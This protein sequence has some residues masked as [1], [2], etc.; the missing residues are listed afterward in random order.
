MEYFICF[1]SSDL[2][3]SKVYSMSLTPLITINSLHLSK[4]CNHGEYHCENCSEY[5]CRSHCKD[6]LE[7]FC[8][9]HFEV[10]YND[11]IKPKAPNF[12]I[13]NEIIEPYNCKCKKNVGPYYNPTISEV[14]RFQSNKSTNKMFNNSYS[15]LFKFF[16]ISLRIKKNISGTGFR[17][18]IRVSTFNL[19]VQALNHQKKNNFA[20]PSTTCTF[21]SK[22]NS[23]FTNFVNCLV[24]NN[25]RYCFN[26]LQITIYI[27]PDDLHSFSV[28]LYSYFSGNWFS[29]GDVLFLN[30]SYCVEMSIKLDA[31]L[32][33]RATRELFMDI[34]LDIAVAC[35]V[36]AIVNSNG[37]KSKLIKITQEAAYNTATLGIET[38][39]QVLGNAVASAA[40][41]G[42]V[43]VAF[44]S[45]SI[46]LAKRRRD[47]GEMSEKEFSNKVKKTV[48]E[49]SLKF[50]GGTTG[51]IIGQALIPVPIVGAVVGGFCGSLIGSGICKGINY[52]IFNYGKFNE[53][54]C[55]KNQQQQQTSHIKKKQCVPMIIVYNES[56]RCFE[57]KKFD[58][59]KKN[60]EKVDAKKKQKETKETTSGTT[61]ARPFFKKWVNN[62]RTKN[63]TAPNI[64]LVIKKE[65]FDYSAKISLLSNQVEL[66]QIESNHEILEDLS[67]TKNVKKLVSNKKRL[68]IKD[69]SFFSTNRQSINNLEVDLIKDQKIRAHSF[70]DTLKNKKEKNFIQIS[71]G[72]VKEKWHTL[73]TKFFEE[74]RTNS[75]TIEDKINSDNDNE[76]KSDN[77]NEIKYDNDNEIKYDNDNQIE[78]DNENNLKCEND[79]K[80]QC[81]NEIKF[82]Q[83]IEA[84]EKFKNES[85]NFN[86]FSVSESK[87][88]IDD[89]KASPDSHELSL[90][91]SNCELNPKKDV[92]KS[93]L[94]NFFFNIKGKPF[95]KKK[96]KIVIYS[97]LDTTNKKS[98]P[99]YIK[100][101]SFEDQTS[102]S[103]SF[104]NNKFEWVSCKLK[105][106]KNAITNK[107]RNTSNE[108]FVYF[109]TNKTLKESFKSNCVPTKSILS[110]DIE[111][112]KILDTNQPTSL[113][114]NQTLFKFNTRL[115]KFASVEVCKRSNETSCLEKNCLKRSSSLSYPI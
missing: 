90:S 105:K 106:S 73:N 47:K 60:S 1:K 57:E 68:K 37:F 99:S 49:S 62:T 56:K 80:I 44:S 6:R 65:T 30:L 103:H 102:L 113:R 97:T 50:V 4:L 78:Y 111:E 71:F 14:F 72:N 27:P 29:Q 43:D 81:D 54:P 92:K 13:A 100:P 46:Y 8:E 21:I 67:K 24:Q 114:I 2:S 79:D 51:S 31:V 22:N 28:F 93:S 53:S 17:Q 34:L 41:S 3:V 85:T 96:E 107:E 108:K 16:F 76:I 58:Y 38:A 35:Y 5:H 11:K 98:D 89:N 75:I 32:S 82:V 33:L 18:T 95:E 25:I 59:Y 23:L 83:V 91:S 19:Q 77:D 40:I 104:Q 69:D 9:N 66:S 84:Q 115:K 45:A 101:K 48:F 36:A 52:G 88:E 20:K 70:E 42:V 74:S 61:I 10:Q 12:V 39:V 112:E 110:E 7:D 26:T 109:N 64:D 94:T 87:Q 15:P 63:E 86:L 55:E